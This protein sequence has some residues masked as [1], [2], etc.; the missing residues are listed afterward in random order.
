MAGRPRVTA[1]FEG[2]SA[3]GGVPL[4]DLLGVLEH[5]QFA[6]RRMAEDVAGRE[7]AAGRIPETIR[8]AGSLIFKRTR[9]GSLIAEMELAEPSGGEIPDLGLEALGRLLAGLDE[10]RSLPPAVVR[11]I[12]L[13]RSA[14]HEGIETVTFAEPRSQLVA[15][16]RRSAPELVDIEMTDIASVA[17][18]RVT[19]RLLEVDWRDRTA[20]LHSPGGVVRLAFPE[21]VGDELRRL[22]TQQ[23]TVQGPVELGADGRLRR[24]MLES[25]ESATADNEFWSPPSIQQMAEAQG[26]GPFMANELLGERIADADALL[27]AIFE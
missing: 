2:P 8:S 11:E 20:E 14:M 26:V 7:T 3:E 6:I 10:P 18:R 22:A 15:V 5:F 13:M 27:A 9:K 17:P 4:D 21:G 1:R 23:V 19:G 12:A 25:I 16:L 24:V